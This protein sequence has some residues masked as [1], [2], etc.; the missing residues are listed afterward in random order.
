M[1]CTDCTVNTALHGLHCKYYAAQTALQVLRGTDCTVSTALHRLYLSAA[2]HR[3][4]L[5]IT[6]L[7]RLHSK[8]CAARTAVK[9]LRCTDC[10][11][12]TA[13]HGLHC[14]CCAART[15]LPGLL[16]P[17]ACLLQPCTD[18]CL[19]CSCTMEVLLSQISPAFF[20]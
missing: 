12:N 4:H 10:T 14:K 13:L 8:C 6:A 9:I 17:I 16:G 18:C 19:L 15:T 7:H 11:V 1:H 2:L 20:T 3:L 5:I